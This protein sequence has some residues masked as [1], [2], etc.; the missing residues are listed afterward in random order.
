MSLT[1]GVHADREGRPAVEGNEALPA[2]GPALLAFISRIA[3]SLVD[4]L[5][6]YK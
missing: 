4:E 6:Y 1:F 2:P 5:F 3:G